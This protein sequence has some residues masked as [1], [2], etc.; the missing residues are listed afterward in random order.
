VT[1]PSLDGLPVRLVA[2]RAT[3]DSGGVRVD[4]GCARQ[5]RADFRQ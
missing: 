5:P 3:V 2:L 1:V 4:V